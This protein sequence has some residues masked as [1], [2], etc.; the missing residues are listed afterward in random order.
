MSVYI[1]KSREAL[2]RLRRDKALI[3]V[4]TTAVVPENGKIPSFSSVFKDDLGNYY[5][6]TDKP[7]TIS[8]TRPNTPQDSFV[9][10]FKN[11]SSRIR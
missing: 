5:Q 7:A 11:R 6:F 9:L 3:F 2:H 10:N 8:F 1:V 4:G